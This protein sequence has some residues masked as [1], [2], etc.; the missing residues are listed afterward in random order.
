MW[1]LLRWKNKDQEF[2]K[3]AEPKRLYGAHQRKHQPTEVTGALYEEAD[4]LQEAA[5]EYIKK[6]GW[7]FGNQQ[8]RK[9]VQS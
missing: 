9:K 4:T 6:K 3:E 1:D 8:P 2:F 5:A 7:G